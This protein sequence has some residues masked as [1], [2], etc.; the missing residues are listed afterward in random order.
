MGAEKG[1]GK[2]LQNPIL[3]GNYHCYKNKEMGLG[4]PVVWDSVEAALIHAFL[5]PVGSLAEENISSNIPSSPSSPFK[6]G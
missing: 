6:L 2:R 1:G 3:A 4:K 5:S